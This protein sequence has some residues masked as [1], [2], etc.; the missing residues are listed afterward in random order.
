MFLC[1]ISGTRNCNGYSQA[2]ICS[3]QSS[4]QDLEYCPDTACL[5]TNDARNPSCCFSGLH[6]WQAVVPGTCRCPRGSNCGQYDQR[7]LSA[8]VPYN[9]YNGRP[10]YTQQNTQL[11]NPLQD[12]VNR[13]GFC[14][15]RYDLTNYDVCNLDSCRTAESLGVC[16]MRE[17]NA[18]N[19]LL[20]SCHRRIFCFQSGVGDSS[21][22]SPVED[23]SSESSTGQR[24]LCTNQ[25]RLLNGNEVTDQCQFKGIAKV[26]TTY[27]DTETVACNAVYTVAKVQDTTKPT[28]LTSQ[29][30]KTMIET[31]QNESDDIIIDIHIGSQRYPVKPP[32]FTTEDG[33]DGNAFIDINPRFSNLFQSLGICQE[34][35]CPYNP[36]TMRNLINT[37]N[38]KIASWG[39][40]SA[41]T[42]TADGLYETAVRISPNGC[43]D[44]ED[45]FGAKNT[46]CVETI[47]GKNLYCLNDAGAPTYCRAPSTREWILMG[48]L[49]FQS[50]CDQSAEAKVIPFPL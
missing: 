20:C 5:A 1:F 2:P 7:T 18:R 11:F 19:L 47:N 16:C 31:I 37:E 4:S 50:G 27:D 8:A 13:V 35:A 33:P 45:L 29:M 6:S 15:N 43:Q 49:A 32:I 24:S 14:N 41:S 38:C 28:F 46:L 3:S 23:S 22:E 48:V 34:E 39:S 26:T 12:A 44:I 42:Y 25:N 21:D 17:D 10:P 36:D 30:C 40:S 9:S